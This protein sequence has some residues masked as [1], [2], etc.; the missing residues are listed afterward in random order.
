MKEWKGAENFLPL[1]GLPSRF[2]E[3]PPKAWPEP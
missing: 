2:L 3:A 1:G